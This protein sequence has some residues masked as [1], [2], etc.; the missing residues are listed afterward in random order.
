MQTEN[1]IDIISSLIDYGGLLG[2]IVKEWWNRKISEAREIYISEVRDGIFDNID[3]DDTLSICHRLYRAIS[4][5]TAKKNFRLICR[6]VQGLGDNNNLTASTFLKFANILDSLSEEE[7]KIMAY[8]I[9]LHY[10]PKPKPER[11]AWRQDTPYF[12]IETEQKR[13]NKETSEWNDKHA[14]IKK[15]I[16]FNKEQ[17]EQ[18]HYSLLRTGLYTLDIMPEGEIVHHE[19]EYKGPGEHWELVDAGVEKNF[20]F[21]DLMFE[22][23][24]YV[25]ISINM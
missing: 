21:T 8:D 11:I 13:Y 6:L 18:I 16:S 12:V 5:G 3:T 15:Y 17:R 9:W 7:I 4:E 2:G 14:K 20:S 24:K 23:I 22:L 1:A 25:D 19:A 10:N